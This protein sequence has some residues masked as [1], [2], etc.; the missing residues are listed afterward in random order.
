MTWFL[1]PFSKH[2]VFWACFVFPITVSFSLGAEI[3][4][5]A[6]GLSSLFIKLAFL[7]LWKYAKTSLEILRFGQCVLGIIE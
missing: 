6:F 5:G 1:H 7:L 3:I 2:F 4:E